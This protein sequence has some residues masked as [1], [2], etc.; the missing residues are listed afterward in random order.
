[1]PNLSQFIVVHREK[2]ASWEK[3]EEN[4]AKL[5][6]VESAKWVR[7]YFNKDEGIRFCVWISRD[8][9]KLKD[10]FRQLDISWDSITKVEE[11]IPDIW[12]KLWDEHL[13]KEA[14]ADT[15]GF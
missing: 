8:E 3:V 2:A 5:A 10:I 7:T 1:M 13:A 11:T 9:A 15:L 14:T 12:G 4:W 6:N